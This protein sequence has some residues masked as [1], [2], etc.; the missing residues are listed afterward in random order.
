M[1]RSQ[2]PSAI[3]RALDDMGA[4][5]KIEKWCSIIFFLLWPV[6]F[7]WGPGEEL[8]KILVTPHPTT[9]FGSCVNFILGV[10]MVIISVYGPGCG[11]YLLFYAPIGFLRLALVRSQPR[12]E[13]QEK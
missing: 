9:F 12:P 6:F 13:A 2:D 7:F 10:P 1:Q 4:K 11:V 8:W 3:C 5:S